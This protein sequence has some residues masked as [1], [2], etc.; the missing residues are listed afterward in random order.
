MRYGR[1]KQQR[2]A[3]K[4]ATKHHSH[5]S[6][7]RNYWIEELL[8]RF[9]PVGH[10]MPQIVTACRDNREESETG[11]CQPRVS[12]YI[13]RRPPLC[14]LGFK[15]SPPDAENVADSRYEIGRMNLRARDIGPFF[16][17]QLV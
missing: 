13:G 8:E 1:R 6:G 3:R 4:D 11:H 2:Q 5:L 9:A 16:Q 7:L 10:I 15:I 17:G 14:P 12:G